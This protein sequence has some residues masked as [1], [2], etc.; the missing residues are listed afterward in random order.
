MEIPAR[1]EIRSLLDRIDWYVGSN[2]PVYVHCLGGVGYTGTIFGY[3]FSGSGYAPD[4]RPGD[5]DEL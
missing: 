2:Y 4:Q 3:D 5:T 1:S